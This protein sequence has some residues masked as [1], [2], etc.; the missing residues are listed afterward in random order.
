[1][2]RWAKEL[3][4]DT[5]VSKKN[6]PFD[7]A[8]PEYINAY[9]KVLHKPYEADGV[10]FWWIDWQQGSKS[11]MKGLDPLWSLNHY[12]YLDNVQKPDGKK[13]RSLILS[14][15]SGIGSQRYPLGFSGDT[16]ITWAS[17]N[18]QPYF[19]ITAANIGY[20][21]WS[22][23]IGGH[24]FGIKDNELYTRWVQFG[25]FSPIN[26]LHSSNNPL[27]GK[28]PWNYD[29]QTERIASDFLRLRH[30]LIPYLYTMDYRNYKDGIAICEPMYYSY[31]SVYEAYQVKNQYMFGSELIVCPVTEKADKKTHLAKVHAWLPKGRWT[32]I[33][34]GYIYHGERSVDLYRDV[35]SIPV[36]AKEGAIIPLGISKGNDVANPTE[37]EIWVYRGNGEF[38]IYED[39]GG[40]DFANSFAFT[41]FI[42]TEKKENHF[43]I[44]PVQGDFSVVPSSRNYKVCFK[45]I[46]RGNVTVLVN[47]TPYTDFEIRLKYL[48]VMIRNVTPTDKVAIAIEDSYYM[49]NRPLREFG[50]EIL[51]KVQGSC[52]RTAHKYSFINKAKTDADYIER[53]RKSRFSKYAKGAVMELWEK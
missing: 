31:P 43:F 15:F 7:I 4:I 14:R 19:T 41:K 8:S 30:K 52:I 11:K 28:E 35:T 2:S 32:D 27:S 18:Y 36:L 34:T 45:D 51:S 1:M 20:T 21:W 49:N 37:L 26:R 29:G 50:V 22:H 48:E 38:A 12:H 42:Q 25:V 6:I 17:L 5:S 47:G 53:V 46:V 44:E 39:K 13:G 23:D 16:S 10:D 24:M 33:F 3:H 9:F 40:N